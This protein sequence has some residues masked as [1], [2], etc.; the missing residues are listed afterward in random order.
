MHLIQKDGE[1]MFDAVFSWR[2]YLILSCTLILTPINSYSEA[3]FCLISVKE[4]SKKYLHLQ[5][6]VGENSAEPSWVVYENSKTIIEIKK[7]GEKIISA[8]M[9]TPAITKTSWIEEIN[10]RKTGEYYMISAGGTF[11]EFV[12]IRGRD[13]KIFKFREDQESYGNENCRWNELIKKTSP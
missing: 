8:D 13:N 12:Y 2:R 10:G 4:H 6:K 11:G 5:L 1:R 3:K 9:N 7:N